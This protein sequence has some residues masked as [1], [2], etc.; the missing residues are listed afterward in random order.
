MENLCKCLDCD[1]LYIDTNPQVNAKK[2]NIDSKIKIETLIG[3]LCPKCYTDDFLT[4]DVV[5]SDFE[6][7]L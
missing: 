4:D 7:Y 1:T 3:H 6:K 2:L 5:E